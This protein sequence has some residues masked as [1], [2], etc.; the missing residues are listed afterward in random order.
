MARY[1]IRVNAVCPGFV[2]TPML[3]QATAGQT[4]G[5]AATV[6]LGRLG[7]PEDIA[8]AV[9]YLLS[10]DAAYITGSELVVDGGHI[11]T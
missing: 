4:G 10:D 2:D 7:R 9:R 5:I 3:T 8:G 6:P 1:G 11:R